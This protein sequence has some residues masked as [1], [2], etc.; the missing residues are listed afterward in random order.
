MN[1]DI[2]LTLYIS[3]RQTFWHAHHAGTTHVLTLLSG[4]IKFKV[5]PLS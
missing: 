2:R 3:L 4:G 1:V 5:I